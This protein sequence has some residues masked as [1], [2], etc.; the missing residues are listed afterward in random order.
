MKIC[1]FASF[2]RFNDLQKCIFCVD[3]ELSFSNLTRCSIMLF[4]L[5]LWPSAN[6]HCE[7]MVCQM[8]S[9]DRCHKVKIHANNYNLALLQYAKSKNTRHILHPSVTLLYNNIIF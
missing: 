7:Q 9:I 4:F 1:K 2:K 8:D 6:N 3:M 5:F